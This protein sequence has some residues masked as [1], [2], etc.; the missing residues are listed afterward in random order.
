MRARKPQDPSQ[1]MAPKQTTV[2]SQRTPS[3]ASRGTLLTKISVYTETFAKKQEAPKNHTLSGNASKQASERTLNVTVGVMTDRSKQQSQMVTKAKTHFTSPP[4][5]KSGEA[6]AIK[7]T[8]AQGKELKHKGHKVLP[9]FKFIAG[10]GRLKKQSMNET[11]LR[12]LPEGDG[13]KVVPGKKLNFSESQ[14]VIITK[15]EDPRTNTKEMPAPKTQTAIP[16]LLGGSQGKHIPRNQSK[17]SSSLLAPQ[18][19]MFQANLALGGELHSAR[20]NVTAKAQTAGYQQSHT[21]APENPGRH[22]VLRVDVTLSPRD[23][24]APGQFG[25]P[26]VVPPGKKEEADRRWKEGNFNVYLSDLIPVD[27]A[28]EDTRPAG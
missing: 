18:R 17:T 25:R 28:I 27:R 3:T 19:A 15:E 4:V 10:T 1:H 9:L 11:R 20:R 6:I 13:A 26:V 14:V 7:K 8:E 16:E 24:N 5:L 2:L 22:R 23:P 21:N 12:G